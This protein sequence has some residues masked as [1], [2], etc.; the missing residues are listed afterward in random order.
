MKNENSQIPTTFVVLGATGDLMTKK[1]VPALFSLHEKGMLP[2]NFRIVGISRRDWTDEDLKR[3]IR[4]ILE[5]KAKDALTAAVDSFLRRVI[6]HKITFDSFDDYINLGDALKKIDAAHGAGI[7]SNKL[8]YLSVSPQFY[9]TI[10]TNIH[11][12]GLTELHDGENGWTRVVVEKP[13]GNDEKTAIALDERISKLFKEDQIYRID[14]YLAKETLQNILT[15]R[16]SN[17]LFEDNWGKG[18]IEKIYVRELE[19]VG[20]EDRGPFYEGVGALKDV[21]QNHLLEMIALIT[22]E[23]PR[24]MSADAIRTARAAILEKL[25][26]LSHSEI[27][28]KTF[29]AQYDGYRTIKGV[30]PKSSIETYFKVALSLADPRWE[31]VP[32][33]MEAG[34]RVVDKKR[35]GEVTEI[36][37]VLKHEQPCL[38]PQG[39]HLKNSITFRQDPSESI[40]IRLWAKKPGLSME[41]EERVFNLDLRQ[42]GHKS[43]YTEEYERLL[44]DCIK[45]DQTLFVS[46]REVV[47]M[48]HF[49]DPIVKGWEKG[50]VP[51]RHYAPDSEAVV[52]EASVLVDPPS[53]DVSS[54]NAGRPKLNKEIGIFGLGKMGA[55]VARQ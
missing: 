8:F 53:E 46:S 1:I 14:H 51:L 2:S 48:W 28:K 54:K 6:Y 42:G 25:K 20:A 17:N 26:P 24:D 27:A 10:F 31:G 21:G 5:V 45:G 41:M 55:N 13:F 36:E 40:T 52:A 50:L 37:V 43:Q 35:D 44:L 15:F 12:A 3:H 18:F 19:N 16:F 47:A 39:E 49:I 11:K 38:C 29:R 9:S 4:T 34:K 30:D 22:M 33:I 7:I 32:I 23:Q